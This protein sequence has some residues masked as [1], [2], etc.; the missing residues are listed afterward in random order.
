[1]GVKPIDPPRVWLNSK[2]LLFLWAAAL[3][4]LV[5]GYLVWQFVNLGAPPKLILKTPEQQTVTTDFSF[6]E[7]TAKD[8]A[9][10][11][12]N[13][14]PILTSP[15]GSFKEKISLIDGVNQVRVS[16]KNK[17]GKTISLTRTFIAQIPKPTATN[18]APTIPAK[19]DGVSVKVNI[20]GP[21]SWLIVTADGQE[22][23]RGT[24]LDGTTQTFNA[25]GSLKLS[26]GN[27]GSVDL[28]LTNNQ[29][30]DKDLGTV[31][32]PNE[33]KRDLVF[34]KDTVVK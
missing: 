10:V 9:D 17:L 25:A 11:Y 22:I 34:N 24:M 8:G 27:A 30:V 12:I 15:D 31:G 28:V 4:F 13:D 16:A 23:F 7:G 5:L 21:A 18:E 1:L 20:R 2:V 3:V 32:A 14:S 6:V 19:I 26:V 33:V 29:V